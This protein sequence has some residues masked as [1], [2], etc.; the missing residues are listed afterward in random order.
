MTRQKFLTV[1]VNNWLSLGLGL[2]T[3]LYVVAAFSMSL[4]PLRSGLI[5]L[6]VFGALF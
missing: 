4:W 5:G 3:L 1:R 2:P 6:A